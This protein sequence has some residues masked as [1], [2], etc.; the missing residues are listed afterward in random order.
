MSIADALAGA[1]ARPAGKRPYFYAQ[2]VER[3]LN[4]TLAVA[5]ELAVTRQRLD[6]VERLLERAGGMARAD[7][8]SFDPTPEQAAERGLW[9]EEYTLRIFRTVQQ[10]LE[11]VA[12]AGEK[13]V[14]EVSAAMSAEKI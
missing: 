3:V 7:I 11:A 9:N 2:D 13:S 6:T 14:E 5:Q 8:E 4:I 10:E 1:S 12:A